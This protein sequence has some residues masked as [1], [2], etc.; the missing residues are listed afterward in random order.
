[1]KEWHCCCFT[2]STDA[3]YA[4]WGVFH[5][6]CRDDKLDLSH[7]AY[8]DCRI[9]YKLMLCYSLVHLKKR[10]RKKSLSIR[11]EGWVGGGGGNWKG[12]N[13][14]DIC[15]QHHKFVQWQKLA[16]HMLY[17]LP[18]CG[19][20]SAYFILFIQLHFVNIHDLDEILLLIK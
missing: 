10:K 12:Q 15:I 2:S 13:H 5:W 9:V 3:I 6:K 16:F 20:Y 14:S 19:I 8:L 11:K 1:M 4:S 18:C 17:K 7:L